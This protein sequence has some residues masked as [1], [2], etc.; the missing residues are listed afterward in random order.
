MTAA[1]FSLSAGWYGIFAGLLSGAIIGLFF[2]RPEWL[3]GYSAFPRRMVRL[4]HISF[5]GLGLL[6]LCY[7]FTLASGAF[8]NNDSTLAMTGARLFV[9]AQF[10]M[11]LFCFLTAWKPKCRH[12][13][14]IPVIASGAG[15]ICILRLLTG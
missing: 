5:L 3:G 2:H 1:Q 12:G 8:G 4:G 11:P 6:Q 9:V 7:G 14:P 10:T 15:V 13:F